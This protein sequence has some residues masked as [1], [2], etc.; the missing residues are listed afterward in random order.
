MIL[1]FIGSGGRAGGTHTLLVKLPGACA[2]ASSLSRDAEASF[3]GNKFTHFSH[4]QVLK[5]VPWT[6]RASTDGLLK[7][8]EPK[9]T[10]CRCSH[11][12]ALFSEEIMTALIRTVKRSAMAKE[13]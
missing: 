8:H 10:T 1:E 3:P 12:Y 11:L 4:S 7:V 6:T 9:K 2:G 13:R 5:L